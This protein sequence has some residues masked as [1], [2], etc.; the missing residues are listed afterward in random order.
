MIV[1][2]GQA[3]IDCVEAHTPKEQS[4]GLSQTDSLADGQGMLFVHSSD[5]LRSYW[6]PISMRFGIDIVFIGEDQKVR[7]ITADRKP[8]EP[9][10]CPGIAKWVLEVPAGFCARAG[11]KQGEPVQ[12]DEEAEASMDDV[13][14]ASTSSDLLRTLSAASLTSQSTI[15]EDASMSVPGMPIQEFVSS[16]LLQEVNRL[17]LHPMGLA[18]SVVYPNEGEPYLDKIVDARSDPE[19]MR[20]GTP[21]PSKAKSVQALFEAKRAQREAIL[22]YH[23]Q[24]V[25]GEHVA[26]STE[27]AP[28]SR[29]V[30][31]SP[32]HPEERFMHQTLLDDQIA[33]GGPAVSNGPV[34]DESWNSPTRA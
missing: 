9:G 29:P 24:P 11:I 10:S 27:T 32:G 12:F 25:P 33:D 6:M 26:Q 19:G 17:L 23:V 28:Y 16:G 34:H 31:T 7:K 22:G 1:R 2:I 5:A 13:L 18:V 3:V 14:E 8:G 30:S 4:V 21:D 20:F 15:S